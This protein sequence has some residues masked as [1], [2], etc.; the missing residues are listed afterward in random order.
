MIGSIADLWNTLRIQLREARKAKGVTQEWVAHRMSDDIPVGERRSW[1]SR[2]EN[3]RAVPNVTTAIGI[4]RSLDLELVA[5]PRQ[6]AKLLT[7]DSGEAALILRA[8]A[9]AAA[10]MPLPAMDKYRVREALQKV[11]L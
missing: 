6:T 10:G 2:I 5:V 8:A 9:N 3:G 4:A 7:L 1:L 11:N